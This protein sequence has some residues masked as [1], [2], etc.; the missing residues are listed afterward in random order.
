MTAVFR[1]FQFSQVAGLMRTTSP[2]SFMLLPP[3]MGSVS[4]L[5]L[6]RPLTY[7]HSIA[8]TSSRNTPGCHAASA[9]LEKQ[10]GLAV[11][12][13]GGDTDQTD[14]WPEILFPSNLTRIRASN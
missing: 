13:C 2:K 5:A 4:A 7:R 12:R 8:P 10:P 1:T 9:H 6:R 11:S 3:S 14:A